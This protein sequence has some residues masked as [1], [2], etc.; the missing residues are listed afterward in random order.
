MSKLM[1]STADKEKRCHAAANNDSIL[2]LGELLASGD[3]DVNCRGNLAEWTPLHTAASNGHV[4]SIEL[5]LRYKATI[6]IPDKVS[7][8]SCGSVV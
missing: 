8:D 7:E 1:E 4:S 6:D 2:E 5:L 3:I